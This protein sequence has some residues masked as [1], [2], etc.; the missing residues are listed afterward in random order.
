MSGINRTSRSEWS[1]APSS[2]SNAPSTSRNEERAPR[3]RRSGVS[4][5]IDNLSSWTFGSSSSRRSNSGS[6]TAP[7]NRRPAPSTLAS[8]ASVLS[9]GSEAS[10]D[11]GV[12]NYA[13]TSRRRSP[14]PEESLGLGSH[15]EEL[16]QYSRR[17]RPASTTSQPASSSTRVDFSAQGVESQ[18]ISERG[19]SLR[20]TGL[21]LCT[22]VAVGGVRRG[23]D[24]SVAS[25]SASVYHLLPGVRKPGLDVVRQINSL[26]SDGYE[27]SAY[28]TGGDNTSQA[29]LQ[30]RAAMEAM[31]TG[32]DVP[33]QSGPPSQGGYTKYSQYLSAKIEDDGQVSYRRG[34]DY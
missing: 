17:S 32:M 33:Y 25:S 22:G 2:S 7:S 24:G 1:E 15:R 3:S 5:L 16:S 8:T 20:T 4:G 12:S 31:L 9:Y 14:V 27:V 18:T 10:A 34:V 13:A 19:Q 28:V 26:R 23:T 6:S 11:S 29:G 21:D 30:Q